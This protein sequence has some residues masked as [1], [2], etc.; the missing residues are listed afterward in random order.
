MLQDEKPTTSVVSTVEEKTKTVKKEKDTKTIKQQQEEEKKRKDA[1]E[2]SDTNSSDTTDL[3]ESGTSSSRPRRNELKLNKERIMKAAAGNK[4]Q[5][6]VQRYEE[7]AKREKEKE[8]ERVI[9]VEFIEN[10]PVLSCLF[11]VR[12]NKR[13]QK[14]KLLNRRK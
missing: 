8:A 14:H 7:Q 2:I 1:S 12:C 10:D 5:V 4:V 11:C 9:K 3:S 6:L 13:G